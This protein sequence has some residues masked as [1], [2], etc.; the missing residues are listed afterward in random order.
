MANPSTFKKRAPKAIKVIRKFAEQ[1][2]KTSDVRIDASLNKAI[3]SRGIKSVAHRVRVRIERRRNDDQESKEKFYSYVSFVPV[4][5]FK[6]LQTTT[7][8]QE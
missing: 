3:W 6:G 7:V 8:E 5:S 1:T 4:S 2:M